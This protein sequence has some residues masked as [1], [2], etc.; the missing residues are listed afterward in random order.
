MKR[1]A[2]LF[3]F[4]LVLFL[5]QTGCEPETPPQPQGGTSTLYEESSY[6]SDC[7][8]SS[9]EYAVV[10]VT[11]RGEGTGTMTWT[12]DKT[13]LLNGRVFV[14]EGQ[15]LTIEAGTIIKGAGGSG[16]NASVLIV[17]RGAKIIAEGSRELPIIFTSEA[18]EIA[19]DKSGELSCPG[20]NLAPDFRGLWGGLVL[21]GKATINASESELAVEGI[22]TSE[23]RGLYGGSEDDDNSG[24]LRYVSIR[25]GGSS[26]GADNEINGLTLGAVGSGTTIDYVEVIANKDDGV[27]FF[28]GT[29]NTKHL[30]M[31]FCGDDAFDADEGYRGSNQFWVAFQDETADNGGEHDGGPSDCLL[32]EPYTSFIVHNATFIGNSTNRAL[33]LRENCAATYR[34]SIFAHYDEG[35]EIKDDETLAQFDA[36][37]LQFSNNI[38][39]EINTPWVA[40]A[41]DVEADLLNAENTTGVD[42]M[43]NERF[44]PQTSMFGSLA[45]PDNALIEAVNYK[46]AF[47]PAAAGR[48]ID[49]WT[50]TATIK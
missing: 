18:D 22:P 6:T 38:F 2:S 46:G 23:I 47:D 39:W 49:D 43:L 3:F 13:Y 25:H 14:N 37:L 11:D 26:I 24:I 36:G 31:T 45:A 35:L 44:V 41:A 50:L 9:L 30:V 27:E 17:A 8:G 15:T 32:C 33:R 34:N 48:W 40:R 10:K 12:K 4:G 16:E 5:L 28:G 7:S 20:G 19:R 29:V 1:N 21:L 42:P